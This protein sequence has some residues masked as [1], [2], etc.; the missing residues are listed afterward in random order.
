MKSELT[1][2][3]NCESKELAERVDEVLRDQQ[4][5]DWDTAY[6]FVDEEGELASLGTYGYIIFLN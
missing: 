6:E 1:F 3:P 2:C 5:Q 4:L